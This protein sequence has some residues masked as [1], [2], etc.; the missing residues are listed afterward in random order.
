MHKLHL[1]ISSQ[2]AF[3]FLNTD[4]LEAFEMVSDGPTI[5]KECSAFMCNRKKPLNLVRLVGCNPR[6]LFC[7]L[8]VF[9][10]KGE[11]DHLS[12]QFCK[13]ALH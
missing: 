11:R 10:S 4:F 5:V 2:L 1:F 7:A 8:H 6:L 9:V 3:F 13:A 12:Y